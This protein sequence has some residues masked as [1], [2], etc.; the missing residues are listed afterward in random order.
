VGAASWAVGAASWAG[1][2]SW[3]EDITVA[4]FMAGDI[5]VTTARAFILVWAG[6]TIILTPTDTQVTR[7][8]TMMHTGIGLQ[9]RARLLRTI[10]DIEFF[11]TIGR[12]PRRIV[13]L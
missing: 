11:E 9:A 10:T 5:M 3:G 7:A 2:D 12:S 8:A 13:R 6:L 1:V 4:D